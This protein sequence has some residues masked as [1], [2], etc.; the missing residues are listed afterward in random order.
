MAG[1][2][3]CLFGVAVAAQEW[4]ALVIGDSGEGA[5]RAFADSYYAA[6]ALRGW[7]DQPAQLLRN[8]PAETVKAA[9]AEVQGQTRLVLYYAG[10]VSGTAVRLDGRDLP[11]APLV[12]ALAGGGLR[13][14]LL[15]VENCA[16]SEALAT[17]VPEVGTPAG[18]TLVVASSAEAGAACPPQGQRLSDALKAA[19]KSSQAP[20]PTLATFLR[21]GGMQQ[22]PGLHAAHS[23]P[24]P[25][26]TATQAPAAP[27]TQGQTPAT[28]PAARPQ[29]QVRITD[30]VRVI[31]A[32][33]PAGLTPVRTP[34]ATGVTPLDR[35]DAPAPVVIFSPVDRTQ[36][37]AQP[38]A[39]GLPEPSIIVGLI[40]GADQDYA[41]ALEAVD[42]AGSEISYDNVAARQQLRQQDP[43]LF[44]ALVGDGAFDPP[45]PILVQALQQELARMGCYTSR[46]DGAW[47]P[48]S[49][50]AVRRYYAE[51]GAPVLTL[52][53]EIP[54]FRDIIGRADVT[55]ARPVAAAR[56]AN[57]APAA[58]AARQPAAA[59]PS[60]PAQTQI[61]PG[62]ALGGVFR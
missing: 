17:A 41:A 61:A 55:C 14:L 35:S 47:G 37:A 4:P 20:S 5:G 60:P 34:A 62:T 51:A 49:Q 39:D 38:R 36:L 9:L 23:A 32:S 56:P 2:C 53:A 58:P 44:A 11:L 28:A 48:G 10:P 13:N 24:T 27:Q 15:L 40:E 52:A 7:R 16:G 12:A 33:A 42:L 21:R 26:P 57:P 25:A 18:L 45:G 31:P 50:G 46:V 43:E 8:A 59:A 29:E 1:A 22:L 30:V 6:E 54:L 3:G 19:A